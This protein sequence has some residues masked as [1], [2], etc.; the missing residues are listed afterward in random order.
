VG[1]RQGIITAISV[2]LGFSL[3]FWRFWGFE[4]PGE[5]NV[6]SLL[7]GISLVVAVTL[8]IV[9]LFRSLRVEDDDVHEYRKTV[10]WL[11][12]STGAMLVSLC[13]AIVEDYINGA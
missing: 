4:S 8:Q 5:W 2:L 11:I 3:A 1:Y 6:G 7:V 13:M 12:A 10:R 9:A